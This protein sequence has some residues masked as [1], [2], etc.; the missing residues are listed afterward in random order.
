MKKLALILLVLCVFQLGCFSCYFVEV[1]R[2]AQETKVST[3][4]GTDLA[5]FLNDKGQ[6]TIK[7]KGGSEQSHVLLSGTVLSKVID[8]SGRA[9]VK[10]IFS[11]G[12]KLADFSG[13]MKDVDTRLKLKN[14]KVVS[15]KVKSCDAEGI[16]FSQWK[17]NDVAQAA[18]SPRFAWAEVQQI[19]SPDFAYVFAVCPERKLSLAPLSVKVM[20]AGCGDVYKT[21]DVKLEFKNDQKNADE[22][23]AKVNALFSPGKSDSEKPMESCPLFWP[24]PSEK[25]KRAAPFISTK[26]C[27]PADAVERAKFVLPEGI[28]EEAFKVLSEFTPQRVREPAVKMVRNPRKKEEE[29][30]KSDGPLGPKGELEIKRP[31]QPLQ[32]IP[33]PDK[34]K[35]PP[36]ENGVPEK[37]DVSSIILE[38]PISY[39]I[40][41]PVIGGWNTAPLR[42][43]RGE[44]PPP[45]DP[46]VKPIEPVDP[47][48]RAHNH[49]WVPPAGKVEE[50]KKKVKEE[51]EGGEKKGDG[52][53]GRDGKNPLLSFATVQKTASTIA[54]ISNGEILIRKSDEEKSEPLL[55]GILLKDEQKIEDKNSSKLICL[56][57]EGTELK[58]VFPITLD[59]NRDTVKIDRGSFVGFINGVTDV[60]LRMKLSDNTERIIA[61][62]DILSLES[63]RICSIASSTS[64]RTS[65]NFSIPVK[66]DGSLDWNTYL[67]KEDLWPG[68]E[69]VLRFSDYDTT[70]GGKTSNGTG[71]TQI[72]YYKDG[73]V[74]GFVRNGQ[75]VWYTEGG[76]QPDS[77][78]LLNPPKVEAT[79]NATAT[80]IQLEEAQKQ[81]LC[82]VSIR[83][84]NNPNH[85]EVSVTSKGS[86]FTAQIAEKAC[87]LS[88]DPDKGQNLME[89]TDPVFTVPAGKT[90]VIPIDTFCISTKSISPPPASGM[91]YTAGKYPDAALFKTL[92]QIAQNAR[93]L[94]KEGRFGNVPL[95]SDKRATKIAQTAI[96]MYLGKRSGKKIDIV[97]VA[98]LKDD[99]LSSG[100]I[101]KENLSDVQLKKVE[102]FATLIYSAA[103]RT[104]K[105]STK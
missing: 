60:G 17:E 80:P 84:E 2:A 66:A 62:K 50:E 96:W 76:K 86:A 71:I 35:V 19:S 27:D 65:W 72:Y 59:S 43:G 15:G 102:D 97:S 6:I 92:V 23:D 73:S 12:E 68:P 53:K 100:Q 81:G 77:S 74:A 99:L 7:D 25:G 24:D 8:E 11:E 42:E 37:D 91:K 95:A 28:S 9:F 58:K 18:E 57:Y 51:K 31:P 103:E 48:P 29:P 104:V 3:L 90:V 30:K 26:A 78:E 45:Y 83:S 22:L 34:N 69:R 75:K 63:S 5:A 10:C 56:F 105:E 33:A 101:S 4:L 20:F 87:F 39:L 55:K 44:T 41:D 94:D 70:F 49:V 67:K 88:S 79:A 93:K 16:S 85:C 47:I 64:G 14:N 89:A 61:K 1:A 82:E 46:P 98:S 38:V 36:T 54:Q 52:E 40:T 32:D 13:N 21:P